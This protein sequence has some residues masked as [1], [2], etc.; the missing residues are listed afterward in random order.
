MMVF[1]K[2]KEKNGKNIL[3]NVILFRIF[4]FSIYENMV[5]RKI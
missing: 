3:T 1:L 2:K 4:E 5:L